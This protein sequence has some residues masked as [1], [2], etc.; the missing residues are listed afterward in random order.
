MKPVPPHIHQLAALLVAEETAK[1]GE[2]TVPPA[3]GVCAR[4]GVLLTKLAGAA[5]YRSLL[6][7]SLAQAY[8]EVPWLKAMQMQPDG[9]LHGLEEAKALASKNELENGGVILVAQLLHLLHIFIGEALTL[10]LV[11]E[12]WPTIVAAREPSAKTTEPPSNRPST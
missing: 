5:G 11:K 9:S 4:L 8:A 1:G 7:R 3:F 2:A 6:A 10:Q 12:A